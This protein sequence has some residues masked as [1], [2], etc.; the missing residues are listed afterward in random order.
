MRIGIDARFWHSSNTGIGQYT[1]GLVKALAK[2]DRKNEY[3]IFLRK[4]DLEEWDI[5]ASN[6][7]PV[8]VDIMHY[9]FA[10]QI[11]LPWIFLSHRLDLIHF[12][13]FN[14]PILY[15]GKFVVT[16][17]DLARYVFPGVRLQGQ[18]FKW[19]Y[20][21]TMWMAVRRANKII[22]VTKY[23]RDEVV[24]K[25][26]GNLKKIAVI[27]EGIDVD[28]FPQ[29]RG[30]ESSLRERYGL[31]WPVLFYVGNWRSHKNIPTLLDAFRI[32]RDKGVQAH[33]VLGGKAEPEVMELIHKHTYKKDIVVAGF[34]ANEELPDYYALADVF[35]YPSLYEGFG[36]QVLEAQYMG[37]PVAASNATTLPEV[38]SDAARYFNPLDANDLALVVSSILRSKKT[39]DTLRSRGL[40]N[41]KRF[42]WEKCAKET[43]KVFEEVARVRHSY[44]S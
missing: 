43:L 9:S 41:L 28:R 36:L 27:L 1:K 23:T 39:Q 35:V 30:V 37:V 13:N 33:L 8:V 4:K 18:I 32:M 2:I 16:I 15:P 3:V 7:R 14:F 17:H 6:F 34:I 42:S 5:G 44:Q 19:G 22:A 21:L 25:L 11:I 31:R 10:E 12:A 24:K 20:Y 29:R 26:G 38:G 40:R